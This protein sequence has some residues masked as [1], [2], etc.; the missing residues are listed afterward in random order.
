MSLVS[1]ISDDYEKT[2]VRGLD[3]QNLRG[4]YKIVI[5]EQNAHKLKEYIKQ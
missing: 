1:Q 5:V 3:T 4:K 2:Q